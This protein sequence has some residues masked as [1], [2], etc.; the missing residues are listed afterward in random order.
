MADMW[1]AEGKVQQSRIAFHLQGQFT[2]PPLG[3]LESEK[4]RYA[5]CQSEEQFQAWAQ[6]W[7]QT[8]PATFEDIPRP[9]LEVGRVVTVQQ[10]MISVLSLQGGTRYA[11]KAPRGKLA[12]K[13]HR[14]GKGKGGEEEDLDIDG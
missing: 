1:K 7:V 10:L 6:R 9:G 14:K 8:D 11:G 5:S 2:I 13:L 12:R 4:A 3:E